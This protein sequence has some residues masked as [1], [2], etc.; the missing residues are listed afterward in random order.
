MGSVSPMDIAL[1]AAPHIDRLVLS[2]ARQVDISHGAHLSGL[3]QECGLE[4]LDLIPH[5]ADF[6]LG[7][8]L[9]RELAG[10]RLRYRP[11]EQVLARLDEL[12][13]KS[14]IRQTDSGLVATPPLR[15]L[16]EALHRAQAEVAAAMWGAHA[17]DVTAAASIARTVA[18]AASTDHTVAAVH[19]SLPEP[20]DPYLLLH[21]RLVTL[22][23]IRQHDHAVAWLQHGLT[24]AEMVV[25]TSLWQAGRVVAPSELGRLIELGLAET[26]PPRLTDHGR[27]VREAIE[28]E[29]NRRAQQTF[30]VLDDEIA[31]EFLAALQR[32]P[33]QVD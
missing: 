17:E 16:L 9:T 11:S 23:Y 32:L 33:G 4:T 13:E 22:R 27:E 15:P 14:L 8:V 19:R 29:T 6:L 20:L 25:L 21:S 3:A 24:A 10:V 1:A 26:D 7:G 31:G 12:A 30:D 28:A 5:L 18:H 2:V